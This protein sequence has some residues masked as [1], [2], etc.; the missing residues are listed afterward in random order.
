L[1]GILKQKDGEKRCYPAHTHVYLLE[2][3]KK[4]ELYYPVESQAVLIPQLLPVP[5][6]PFT[7]DDK[8]ALGFVLHYH[9]FLPPSV[10]PRFLV[11]RHKQI[12]PDLCWRTGT[13]LCDKAVVKADTEAKRIYLWVNDPRR[14]EFLSFLW[15]TLREINDSF[16]SERIPMPDD[17]AC[18]ADYQTLIKYAENKADIYVAEGSGKVYSVRQL[19]GTIEPDREDQLLELLRMIKEQLDEKDAA[20]EAAV[21]L[22]ELFARIR[23]ARRRKG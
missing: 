5:E 17:P 8:S 1:D 22:N 12:K 4:F 21:N 10:M 16:V 7:F 15:F 18:S 2:L 13:V 20:D 6:P 11:K 9:S 14:K 23:G 3:M 19:L